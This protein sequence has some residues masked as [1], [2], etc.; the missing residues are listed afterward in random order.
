MKC[1]RMIVKTALST[2]LLQRAAT[3]ADDVIALLRGKARTF[4]DKPMHMITPAERKS[5][6]EVMAKI[7]KRIT[8]ANKMDD[9][10]AK[11]INYRAISPG[12]E[13]MFGITSPVRKKY[14]SADKWREL[15]R[16]GEGRVM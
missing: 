15:A 11:R 16:E 4:S 12:H 5:F 3:K 2:D 8:G 14:V 9:V 7:N 13:T 6:S 1:P 10:I